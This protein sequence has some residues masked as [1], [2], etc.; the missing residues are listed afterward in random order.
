MVKMEDQDQITELET[1]YCKGEVIHSIAEHSKF[2][3]AL[4]VSDGIKII[5]RQSGKLV[6]KIS[7]P[8]TS[9]W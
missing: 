2:K 3:L 1:R 7:A 9:G 5:G 8:G 4:C 6:Q